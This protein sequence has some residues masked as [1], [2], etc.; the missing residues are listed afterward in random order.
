MNKEVFKTAINWILFACA[1]FIPY[2]IFKTNSFVMNGLFDFFNLANY[3]FFHSGFYNIMGNITIF[4]KYV[5]AIL[6]FLALICLGATTEELVER[7]NL[8]NSLGAYMSQGI[9]IILSLQLIVIST[10]L[11]ILAIAI[12]V[13]VLIVTLLTLML[14]SKDK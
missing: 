7:V 5:L 6:L 4:L 13:I 12:M 1:I 11:V 8:K 14:T 10:P 9:S 3:S 2:A